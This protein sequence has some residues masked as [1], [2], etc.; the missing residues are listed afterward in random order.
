MLGHESIVKAAESNQQATN[1]VD[2]SNVSS[3]T[4]PKNVKIVVITS[5]KIINLIPKIQLN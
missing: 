2:S 1:E 3:D 5:M 4:I